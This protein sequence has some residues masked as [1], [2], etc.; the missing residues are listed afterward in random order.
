M[1]AGITRFEEIQAWQK[2][3]EMVREVYGL[4]RE[5]PLGKDFGLRD[6]ICRASVSAMSNIAEGFAKGSNRDFA[7]FLDIARGVRHRGPVALVCRL[8]CGAYWR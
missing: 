3:R 4:C 2:A 5:N 1:M 8:G 7:R 6:Q